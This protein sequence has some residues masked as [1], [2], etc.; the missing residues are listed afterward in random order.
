M[1][2]W[3]KA[4]QLLLSLSLLIVL[5]ELGHFIPAK[6][7]KTRVEKFYLFFD[8]WFS[9]W[10][11]KKGETEYG[12]GWLPLGGY[13][14]ISGMID[15]SMDTEQM[16]K[17][18]EPWEFRSKPVW[19]RLIIMIGGVTVNV[20]VAVL[21]YVM[22]MS[23]WGKDEL[24]PE[25]LTHGYDVPEIVEEYGFRDGD[26]ILEVDGEE[27][28]NALDINRMM[29]IENVSEFK[30]RHE[31]GEIE[32]ITLPEDIDYEFFRHDASF[33]PRVLTKLAI[34]D[35]NSPAEKAGLKKGDIIVSVEG[36][37]VK[38]WNEMSTEVRK[39]YNTTH[40]ALVAHLGETSYSYKEIQNFS[41]N[42]ERNLSIGVLRDGET[43]ELMVPINASKAIGIRHETDMETLFKMKNT[44]YGFFAAIPAGWSEGVKSLRTYAGQMKYVFT[45]KGAKSVGGF[46]AF[47][48]L[49]PPQWEWEAFWRIT[50]FISIILAF[51]NILPIPALDGGHVMFLLYEAI[52]GRPPNQKVLEYAQ[53]AGFVLILSL[54]IYANANDII[55]AIG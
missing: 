40:E 53:I 41:K 4:G 28:T 32:T 51:M 14:K 18:P 52:S 33:S 42:Y 13:V 35:D 46:G 38:Y 7:F 17:D 1:E 8:P 29:L 24:P 43:M 5:H 20:I 6:L 27:L 55:R 16:E 25:N 47:G 30:V 26:V 19:Q 36:K 23:V 21:I 48:N 10:K 3:I 34:V 9:L 12:I 49:F 31:D 11:S 39:S 50:A 15:E 45:K 2:I 37:S 44:T 54:V 22:I